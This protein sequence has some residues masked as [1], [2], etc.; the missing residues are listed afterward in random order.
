MRPTLTTSHTLGLNLSDHKPLTSNP[1]RWNA[2][3]VSRVTLVRPV[4]RFTDYYLTSI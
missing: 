1:V 2:R 3:F 4:D